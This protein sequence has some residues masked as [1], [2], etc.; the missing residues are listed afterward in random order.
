MAMISKP[1]LNG[2]TEEME[3]ERAEM[4]GRRLAWVLLPEVQEKVLEEGRMTGWTRL[5]ALDLAGHQVFWEVSG[6]VLLATARVEAAWKVVLVEAILAAE[7]PSF[8][9]RVG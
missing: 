8:A 4:K 5:S 3:V 1:D 7:E 9:G 6:R 2:R